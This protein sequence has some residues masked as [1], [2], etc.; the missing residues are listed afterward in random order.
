M[1]SDA[2]FHKRKLRKQSELE[3]KSQ[4]RA[5]SPR[6]LI[7]C[8]GTKT[9]PHYFQ[10]LLDDLRIRPQL[11]RVAQNRGVSPNQVVEYAFQLYTS[12]ALGGDS[13]DKVYCV[14]DRDRHTTFNAAV[15]R[16]IELSAAVPSAPLE[17]ITSTPCFEFWFLLH[18][19]YTDQ[20]FHSAGKKSIGDQVVALLKTKAGF[21]EYGKGDRNIYSRLK[22]KLPSAIRSAQEL[23]VNSAAYGSSNPATDVDRLVSALQ[24]LAPRV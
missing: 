4:E 21:N 3:R 17:A 13:F 22:T 5:Q 2:L 9:E 6:Y 19:G 15:R 14:F 24:A 7:V 20:P 1:G 11:V 8:E 16:T 18:F 12:D 23:R 10:D